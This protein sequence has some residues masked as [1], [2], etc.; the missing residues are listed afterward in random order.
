[1]ECRDQGQVSARGR[2][3]ENSR[4]LWVSSP[5]TGLGSLLV[6]LEPPREERGWQICGWNREGD[7]GN[8]T[9]GIT[10]SV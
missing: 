8:V 7:H 2:D 6:L 5:A 3:H 4:D 10:S 1:M 9:A